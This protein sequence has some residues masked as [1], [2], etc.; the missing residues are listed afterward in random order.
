MIACALPA[1]QTTYPPKK[2]AKASETFS[3]KTQFQLYLLDFGSLMALMEKK[4]KVCYSQM[5]LT[6]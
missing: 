5:Y 4:N 6:V 2:E 3:N 1:K